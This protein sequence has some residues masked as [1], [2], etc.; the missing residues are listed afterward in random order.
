MPHQ[1]SVGCGR[2][3]EDEKSELGR[4]FRRFTS[5]CSETMDRCDAMITESLFSTDMSALRL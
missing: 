5:E 4:I 1:G 3:V 2:K